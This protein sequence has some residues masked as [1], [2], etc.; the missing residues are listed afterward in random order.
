MVNK[1]NKYIVYQINISD[2]NMILIFP[3]AQTS[4]RIYPQLIIKYM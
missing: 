3:F 1:W 2:T 4:F